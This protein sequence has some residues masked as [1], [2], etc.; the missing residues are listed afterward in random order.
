MTNK[1]HW[2]CRWF[3]HRW[4][5]A[6]VGNYIWRF[7]AVYCN[8]CYFGNKELHEFTRLMNSDTPGKF[9]TYS[10]EYFT[11]EPDLRGSKTIWIR[12]GELVCLLCRDVVSAEHKHVESRDPIVFESYEIVNTNPRRAEVNNYM[13]GTLLFVVQVCAVIIMICALALIWITK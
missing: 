2:K 7:V 5:P 10:V 6:Y 12:P 1:P 8:R 4:T 9:N 3:G 11:G 13:Q